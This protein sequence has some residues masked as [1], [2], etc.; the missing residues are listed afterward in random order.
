[1]DP[2]IPRKR[3]RP[4]K[5]PL[6]DE[7]NAAASGGGKGSGPDPKKRAV[8][9]VPVA[10][11]GRYVLKE[12][13]GKKFLGKVVFYDTGLYR[14]EYE[15]G[16]Q[17]DLE[18]GELRRIV[19]DDANFAEELSRRRKKLDKMICDASAK[20]VVVPEKNQVGDVKASSPSELSSVPV[21]EDNGDGV[22]GK[23]DGHADS[24]TDSCEYGEDGGSGLESEAREIPPPLQLPP[25]SGSIGIAEEYVSH[26]LS[27][28]GF[29]RSFSVALYL[30]PFGLD[31]FVGA[32]NSSLPN[33]LM[34]AIHVALMRSLRLHLEIVSSEG[35]ELASKCLRC[36]DWDLLDTLTW[37]IY[38]L[39]YLTVMGH[40]R[41]QEWKGFSEDILHRDY[42][43]LPVGNKLL[44]LQILCDHALEC[45]DV[46]AEIDMR[47]ESE[48]GIDLDG[49]A[50]NISQN[51]TRMVHPRYCK[52]ASFLN[53]EAAGGTAVNYEMKPQ[54]NSNC[55]ANGSEGVQVVAD[56]AQLSGDGNGDECRLCG[57]DGTLLCCDGCPSAYHARCIGLVK[58]HIP[59]GSWYCPECTI[60]RIGP[61]ITSGTSLVGAEIFGIDPYEQVFL[62]TRN[63]LLVLKVSMSDKLCLRYYNQ[64]DIVK[65]LETLNSSAQHTTSY[66]KICE[67]I[68]QYWNIPDNMFSLPQVNEMQ[69]EQVNDNDIKISSQPLISFVDGGQKVLGPTG[70]ENMSGVSGGD[71]V[72]IATS[73]HTFAKETTHC[74]IVGHH[75]SSNSNMVKNGPPVDL[76]LL[77]HIKVDSASSSG[78]VTQQADPSDITHQGS[79]DRSS[80]SNHVMC[81]SK[82][83]SGSCNGHPDGMGLPN[84]RSCQN[85]H[86]Y[87][88]GVGG[89]A[90]NV[91]EDCTYTGALFRPQAYINNYIHG[92]IAATAAANLATLSAEE[93]QISE[94]HVAGSSKKLTSANSHQMK[95]FISATPRFFWPISEKKLGEVPRERCGWCYTCKAQV[96]SR[97]G[98]MLNAAALL[99][100]KSTT[101]ILGGLP[102]TKNAQGSLS[103][104]VIYILLI[105]E[106]FRGLIVGPFLGMTQRKEWRERLVEAA[107]CTA[108]KGLLLELEEHIRPI[109]LSG[110]WIKPVDDCLMEASVTQGVSTTVD[111]AHKRGPV[112]RRR[113]NAALSDLPSDDGLDKSFSWWRGGKILKLLMHKA[114][115]PRS[116]VKRAARQGG[117]RKIPGVHYYYGTEIPRRSRQLAWRAA[118]ETSKSASQLALQVRYLD[119]Y[120]RWSDLVRP[121]Q[122][123]QDA[124]GPELESSV[125]RNALVCDKKD[126]EH[127]VSYAVDF[128]IQ[129]HLPSRVM[130]SIIDIEQSEGGKEKYWFSETHIP[131]YLI[132]EYEE[133]VDRLPMPSEEMRLFPRIQ[134]VQFKAAR[135]DIFSLLVYRRDN[136]DKFSCSSCQQDVPLRN[137]VKC[138]SCRGYCHEQCIVGS[139]IMANGFSCRQCFNAKAFSRKETTESPTSPLLL[140]TRENHGNGTIIRLPKV[141]GYNQ[142]LASA[143]P[144][145]NS[146]EIKHGTSGSSLAM[147]S[148][149]KLPTWGVI[150]RKKNCDD[151]GSEFRIKNILLRG[152]KDLRWSGPVCH[153][154]G[155]PYNSDLMYI[156]CQNC[157]HWFH[158]DAVELTESRIFDVVGFKCC[159]C[160]RI[161]S[162]ECPY[163]D[164]GKKRMVKKQ[165]SSA[166]KQESESDLG[167]TSESRE[168]EPTTPMFP[169]EEM[170]IQEEDPLLLSTSRVHQIAD[171]NWEVDFSQVSALGPALQKLPVRRHVKRD[172]V[173][174]GLQENSYFYSESSTSMEMN[175]PMDQI[176]DA[177][178]PAAAWD[179][180]NNGLDGEVLIDFEG[181]DY[182]DMEFEPQTYFSFTELLASDDGD[183][184]DEAHA[185]EDV[186]GRWE[187]AA[188]AALQ[189]G[190]AEDF[191]E[192]PAD[193]GVGQTSSEISGVA[194][195]CRICTLLDPTPDLCCQFCGLCVHSGCSPWGG[196]E[197]G[198]GDWKCGDCREWR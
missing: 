154:C 119:S 84:V 123:P 113:K 64:K 165:Q 33:S 14:I 125:F 26:L 4:R 58:M 111:T 62:G 98:C 54:T 34:D 105:E 20:Q 61:S 127:K 120:L 103:S 175:I 193:N 177:T 35:S 10:M 166:I 79:V 44:A 121:E 139:R 71:A 150:W 164:K 108:V 68:I 43:S 146:Q 81:T 80:T 102:P 157:T 124:K 39:H 1:M 167:N 194:V 66:L 77:E 142:P 109:A 74:E 76:K 99:A 132:K 161:K 7:E 2:A 21:R 116:L 163:D 87:S 181:F 186:S 59:E 168:C 8:S 90:Q 159:K 38:V 130:K 22:D 114:I 140:Q 144:M 112:G 143:R 36:I 95:A 97:R 162:P 25:S 12:F 188:S 82:N 136:V 91:G 83:S 67:G 70:I 180:P 198:E 37:P 190:V 115:L 75:I 29:L 176:G 60:D 192:A 149:A 137:A 42:Y 53:R 57:M 171:D 47:E 15:D 17:E 73:V 46:R 13:N 93:G 18:S 189:G 185:T 106:S 69:R 63:H 50:S 31:E 153:L 170:Q 197:S 172:G 52:M 48:V 179:I 100:T 3:G 134:R 89:A 196:M 19:L 51:G 16:D 6:P 128:G 133:G 110:D 11:L 85:K 78:S 24:S 191:G 169:P 158:A 135:I 141:K 86:C 72:T 49:T 156:R 92:C 178:T 122:S 160:R 94:V 56:A 151:T 5:R 117:L 118:V 30:C 155:K 41:G 126:L 147:K 187:N 129:K 96:I 27:V 195:P 131:L 107:D 182:G 65:V 28:Y 145:Y 88:V 23:G 174:D 45:A 32:L 173:A 104:I 184:I 101:K 40:V 152:D 183:Q 148:R 55:K 9:A 138:S